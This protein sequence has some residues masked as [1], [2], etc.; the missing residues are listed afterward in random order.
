M[1]TSLTESAEDLSTKGLCEAN[2]CREKECIEKELLTQTLP[3]VAFVKVP[4][5]SEQLL[6]VHLTQLY[7]T[8]N[9]L[10]KTD[11]K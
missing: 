9:R 3:E 1:S 4:S 8:L 5:Q 6:T 11:S 7:S 2:E 10:V